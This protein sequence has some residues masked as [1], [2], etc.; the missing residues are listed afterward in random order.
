MTIWDKLMSKHYRNFR[1]LGGVTAREKELLGLLK[2]ML[3][4]QLTDQVGVELLE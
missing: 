4:S 3:D 2:L 1:G